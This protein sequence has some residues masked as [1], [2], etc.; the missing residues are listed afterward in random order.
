MHAE[1]EGTVDRVDLWHSED[2]T[3]ARVID[4]KTGKKG[5]EYTN[6]YHGL[7]LQMLLY[8]FAL[9]KQEKQTELHP[10]GVLYFP[11]RIESLTEP[12]HTDQAKIESDRKKQRKRSGLLLNSWP[13]L[14]AMEPC[15]G[16][17][18]YLPYSY[19]KENTRVGDLASEEQFRTLDRYVYDKVVALGEQLY[20]GEIAPN[21]YFFD[22]DSKNACKWC[23]YQTV[24]N[25]KREER[26][27]EKIKS[28]KDFWQRLEAS[29]G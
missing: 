26:W 6:V 10:A 2:R 4:Y 27:L 5:F 12:D 17:P 15:D 24:C 13:V 18:T 8:L 25:G 9:I 3:F 29:D 22:L 20:S 7:S 11:A 19:D 16:E 1:L 14:Q 28:E 23:P 21:P